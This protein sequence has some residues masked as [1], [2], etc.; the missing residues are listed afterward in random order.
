VWHTTHRATSPSSRWHTVVSTDGG[1][2]S[3]GETNC[4]SESLLDRF[5][6]KG[7]RS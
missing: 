7:V 3:S 5:A 6:D 2:A 4:R 1:S